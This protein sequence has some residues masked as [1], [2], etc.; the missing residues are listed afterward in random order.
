MRLP[1]AGGRPGTLLEFNRESHALAGVE[2]ELN[3]VRLTLTDALGTSL[4]T[5]FVET[6]KQS[7]E[8]RVRTARALFE[9]TLQEA[10]LARSQIRAIGA[11]VPGPVD[12]HSGTCRLAPNL[13]WANVPLRAD[14]T[15]AFGAPVVVANVTTA[16]ALAEM[17]RGVAQDV[18]SFLWV[19]LDTGVGAGLILN[20]QA[21]FGPRGFP[22]ELGHLRVT[23]AP[24]ACGCGGEGHLEALVSTEALLEKLRGEN[25]QPG[26]AVH[27][28]ELVSF[29]DLLARLARGC[30]TTTA[31]IE[32]AG[33]L[34]GLALAQAINLLDVTTI[35]LGGQL[36]RAGTPLLAQVGDNCRKHVLLTD[37]IEIRQSSLDGRAG[38]LGAVELALDAATP[39]YALIRNG[40][41]Q[42]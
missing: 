23:D 41:A 3:G 33:A 9:S 39:T 29:E 8:E 16:S 38:L 27:A 21:Y 26:G 18:S 13:G 2:F 1:W 4:A 42:R 25:S 20:Q 11:I 12:P 31:V 5:Q 35:V 17:R 7:Y 19:Y 28:T 32:E 15:A 40:A 24:V 14:L 34:V 22:S 36:A 37:N 30:P 10:G 6:R